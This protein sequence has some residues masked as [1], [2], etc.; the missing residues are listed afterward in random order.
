MTRRVTLAMIGCGDVAIQRHLPTIAA[1][2]DVHLAACC[3]TDPVRAERA[4]TMFGAPRHT[5]EPGQ[6]L[7]DPGIDA[8]II[9]TPPW[10]TPTLTTDA[11]NAGKDVLAE[12]P[13][14]LTLERAREVHAAERASDRFVQIGFALRHGPLFDTLRRWIADDRLGSPLDVRISVFDEVW[15]PAGDPE[16][17]HR[18]MATL[19][20]GAPCIHD[21]AHTMDHLHFLLGDMAARVTAW[22]RTTRPEF[23]RPNLNLA[24]IEFASGHRARVEIGWF[25][26]QFPT[27]EWTII[28]PR[29]FASFRQ[30]ERLVELRSETGNE[31]VRIEEDWITSCFRYQLEAFVTGVITREPPLPGVADGIASLILC[32]HFEAG[33]FHASQPRKVSY[34]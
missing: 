26:P 31:I 29:G 32:Q 7:A 23:P 11:L 4:A 22:G 16:H 33:M 5:T 13:M 24:V 12:K 28:G 15:N 25:L 6:V 14:A 9:A 21:G 27:G 8:V 3:D 1:N 2:P 20:H 17:Y 18:I 19:A 30:Q 10:I 34:Q